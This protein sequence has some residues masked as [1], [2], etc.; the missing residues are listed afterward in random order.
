MVRGISFPEF[1]DRIKESAKTLPAK[2]IDWH[3]VSPDGLVIWKDTDVR[4]HDVLFKVRLN[5]YYQDR[6]GEKEF[7]PH[8]EI[9]ILRFTGT[10]WEG[11]SLLIPLYNLVGGSTDGF[12]CAT[13]F[14]SKLSSQYL[15]VERRPEISE[16]AR[17]FDKAFFPYRVNQRRFEYV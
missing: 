16:C 13:E 5:N 15:P 6:N 11:P 4:D 10:K 3:R 7:Y 9:A 1:V 2:E 12:E 8:I 14:V 17:L